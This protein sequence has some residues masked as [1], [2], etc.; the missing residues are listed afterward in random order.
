MDL[1]M[2]VMG[3]LAEAAWRQLSVEAVSL[4]DALRG[5]T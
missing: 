1:Q 5:N 2:P 4:I 3:G